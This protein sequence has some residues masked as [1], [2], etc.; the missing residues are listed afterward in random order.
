MPKILK[1]VLFDLR[2]RSDFLN[3]SWET[4]P[5]ESPNSIHPET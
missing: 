5:P 2:Y 3:L 1:W 4:T